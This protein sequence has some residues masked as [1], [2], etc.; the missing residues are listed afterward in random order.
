MEVEVDVGI[1]RGAD[2][3]QLGEQLATG[4]VVPWIQPFD[5]VNDAQ[6]EGVVHASQ[7]SRRRRAGATLWPSG[8]VDRRDVGRTAAPPGIVSRISTMIEG[9]VRLP[10]PPLSAAN[11]MAALTDI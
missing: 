10:V 5:D 9:L 1:G 11:S 7:Y 4:I 2:R 8:E 3:L 6:G